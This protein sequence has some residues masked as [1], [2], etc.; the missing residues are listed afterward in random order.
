MLY[1]H[2]FFGLI[3]TGTLL[4]AVALDMGHWYEHLVSF[5][6]VALWCSYIMS[7]LIGLTSTLS[8]TEPLFAALMI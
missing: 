1:S 3:L 8:E 4:V 7:N 2:I 5:A 6:L